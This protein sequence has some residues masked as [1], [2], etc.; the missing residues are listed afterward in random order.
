MQVLVSTISLWSSCVAHALERQKDSETGHKG[1]NG[2]VPEC[3][4]HGFSIF[5]FSL[6]VLLLQW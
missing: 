3:V 6:G 1:G 2:F 5:A 4:T